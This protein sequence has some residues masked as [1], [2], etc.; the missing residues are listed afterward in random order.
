[1]KKLICVLLLTALCVPFAAAQET[2][3]PFVDFPFEEG[4]DTFMP[5]LIELYGGGPSMEITQLNTIM[6]WNGKGKAHLGRILPYSPESMQICGYDVNSID[7]AEL[8]SETDDTQRK[9]VHITLYF[10]VEPGMENA[11]YEDLCQQITDVYGMGLRNAEETQWVSKEMKEW[12]ESETRYIITEL[13]HSKRNGSY[14]I[15]LYYAVKD[16]EL[17]WDLLD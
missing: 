7:L 14:M 13:W 10:A 15:K 16:F 17:A 8:V 4:I 5:H 6:N 9:M 11:M 2:I 1:M 12:S 3:L